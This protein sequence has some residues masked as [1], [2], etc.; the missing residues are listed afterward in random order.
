MSSV[1]PVVVPVSLRVVSEAD[2]PLSCSKV[3][4]ALDTVS[5]VG[6]LS[7]AAV[8]LSVAAV[9]LSVAAVPSC[10]GVERPSLSE[11]SVRCRLDY[12][13]LWYTGTG[14]VLGA[15]NTQENPPLRENTPLDPLR[16]CL[17]SSPTNVCVR[18]CLSSTYAAI[19][20]TCNGQLT[21][22][23]CSVYVPLERNKQRPHCSERGE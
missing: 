20:C 2:A 10:L 8:P 1:L 7:V 15:S 9:P 11:H 12:N 13:V 19:Q 23:G 21:R 17:V 16:S 6:S 14:L 4:A 22:R 18:Q 3:V 5:A